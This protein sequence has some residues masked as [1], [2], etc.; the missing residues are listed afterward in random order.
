MSLHFILGTPCILRFLDRISEEEEK[1]AQEQQGDN[2][3]VAAD[4]VTYE[5]DPETGDVVIDASAWEN[6]KG[7]SEVC[8]VSIL[9]DQLGTY[10]IEMEMKERDLEDLAQLSVTVYI[11]NI[12]KT[13]ISIRGTKGEWIK[14]TRDLGFFFWPNRDPGTLYFGANGHAAW[15]DPP[16]V[17]RR[18]GSAEQTRGINKKRNTE[19][20]RNPGSRCLR[21]GAGFRFFV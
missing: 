9:A 16:E 5:A 10:D 19:K 8:G 21:S 13:V 11:D 2:D 17:K 14:E 12:V 15:Q 20:N 3:F 1:E 4:L 6:K 7:T 18:H